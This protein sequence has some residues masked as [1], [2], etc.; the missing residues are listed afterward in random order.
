MTAEVEKPQWDDP[1]ITVSTLEGIAAVA[2]RIKG[3]R[4]TLE[5]DGLC[6]SLLRVTDPGRAMISVF[7]I[8]YLTLA[9][10]HDPIAVVED[11]FERIA[12]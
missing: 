4:V 10:A 1:A 8:D 5:H 12:P 11:G 3:A 9:L 7:R 6:L 2:L